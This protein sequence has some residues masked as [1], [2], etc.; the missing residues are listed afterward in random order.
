MNLRSFHASANSASVTIIEAEF[1]T[2]VEGLDF[3]SVPLVF[4]CL[5]WFVFVFLGL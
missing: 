3:G 2:I 4:F 1:T 5:L